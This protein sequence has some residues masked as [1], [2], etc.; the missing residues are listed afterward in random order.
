MY[1]ISLSVG[2]ESIVK[3]IEHQ[4]NIYPNP[5]SNFVWIEN[6]MS[7]KELQVFDRQ[8]RWIQTQKLNSG[9]QELELQLKPGLYIFNFIGDEVH[10]SQKCLIN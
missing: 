10:Y 6:F 4:I 2:E 3:Q 5:A 1:S 9:I 7:A 8:G